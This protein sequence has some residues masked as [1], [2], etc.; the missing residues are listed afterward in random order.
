[1]EVG[2]PS[3]APRFFTSASYGVAFVARSGAT[4]AHDLGMDWEHRLRALLLAGG[5]L[6]VIGCSSQSNDAT[7][8]NVPCGNANPDPCICG[9]PDASAAAAA[10]C[11]EEKA[12]QAQG[13][14]FDAFT[15]TEADGSVSNPHCLLD[16]GTDASP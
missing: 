2:R 7:T 15:E 16:A 9:K 11:D 3:G 1:M 5:T 4:F 13:G 10:L 8:D 12:C 14:T 6:A